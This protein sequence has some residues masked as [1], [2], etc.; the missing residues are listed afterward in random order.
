[1]NIEIPNWPLSSIEISTVRII[2]KDWIFS[3]FKSE[4]Q[5]LYVMIAHDTLFLDF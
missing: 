5:S 1:M 4:R 2:M 3:L